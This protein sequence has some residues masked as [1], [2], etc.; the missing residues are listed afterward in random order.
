MLWRSGRQVRW[1]LDLAPRLRP[2]R[3]GKSNR[4][5]AAGLA[6]DEAAR[7][8]DGWRRQRFRALSCLRTPVLNPRASA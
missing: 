4:R 1:P 2:L 5:G 8:I 3:V 7:Q 6:G